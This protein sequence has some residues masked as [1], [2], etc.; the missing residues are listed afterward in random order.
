MKHGRKIPYLH[1]YGGIAAANQLCNSLNTSEVFLVI[2]S[3][4][5]TEDNLVVS[6]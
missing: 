5:R 1:I 3:G 6:E 2:K 4:I